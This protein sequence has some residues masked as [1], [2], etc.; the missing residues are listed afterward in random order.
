VAPGRLERM[1]EPLYP[2]VAVREAL[3]NAF[4]STVT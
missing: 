2:P 4:C 3:A 1:D